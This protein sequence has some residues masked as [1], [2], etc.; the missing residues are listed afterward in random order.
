[1]DDSSISYNFL[2]N[3]IMRVVKSASNKNEKLLKI[4]TILKTDVPHYDWVGF[5]IG[6]EA[7]KKLTLGPFVGA[8]TE[9]IE[10]AFGSGICI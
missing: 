9:H 3:K 2:T 1:M 8:P 6:D 4:C 10:I 5:Y 7:A